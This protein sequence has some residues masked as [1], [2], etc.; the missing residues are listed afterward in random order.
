MN[1]PPDLFE[2]I[3]GGLSGPPAEPVASDAPTAPAAPPAPPA[4]AA[5][6]GRAE[7]R[8]GRRV[9]VRA[10]VMVLPLTEQLAALPFAVAVRDLSPG[11]FGFLHRRK[12][13]L[14]E[15]FVVMLPAGPGASV[16][17]LCSVAYWQPVAE[18]VY[19]VGARFQRVLRRGTGEEG[20]GTSLAGKS[21]DAAPGRRV[22]S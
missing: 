3:V 16:A 12:I 11:G 19:A 13:D 17:V 7:Q 10:R 15:Q 9:G 18:G 14:D 8:S 2:Q 5:E 1:L 21:A 22:A 6:A 20:A 4:D